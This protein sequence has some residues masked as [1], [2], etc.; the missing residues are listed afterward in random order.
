M[1]VNPT[2]N[3]THPTQAPENRIDKPLFVR[4]VIKYHYTHPTRFSL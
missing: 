1:F 2:K 4:R 3:Y